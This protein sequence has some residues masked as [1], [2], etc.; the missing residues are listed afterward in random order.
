MFRTI[1]KM[2]EKPEKYRMRV[3]FIIS[4]SIAGI[5]FLVWLSVLGVRF[6]NSDNTADKEFAEPALAEFKERFSGVFEE[7]KSQLEEAREELENIVQ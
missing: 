4:A 1:E 3:A 5:I 7:G 6:E 2:R